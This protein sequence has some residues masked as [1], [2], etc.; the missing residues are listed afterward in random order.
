MFADPQRQKPAPIRRVMALECEDGVNCVVASEPERGI[1]ALAIGEV[2]ERLDLGRDFEHPFMEF[3]LSDNGKR[4]ATIPAND[5]ERFYKRCKSDDCKVIEQQVVLSSGKEAMV[6]RVYSP[7]NI[8]GE[9]YFEPE[10]IFGVLAS[11]AEAKLLSRSDLTEAKEVFERYTVRHAA[12]QIV[13]RFATQSRDILRM[14]DDDLRIYIDGGE[15][16]GEATSNEL[17]KYRKYLAHQPFAHFRGRDNTDLRA[18]DLHD[19]F[20]LLAHTGEFSTLEPVHHRALLALVAPYSFGIPTVTP[21]QSIMSR[22]AQFS[23]QFKHAIE[24]LKPAEEDSEL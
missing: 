10:S 7:R 1:L 14:S 5:R 8:Y 17:E 15:E 11:L 20:R 4:F 24:T 6:L 12:D 21:H 13:T 2:E 16:T 23:R 3:H 18:E 19:A 9:H 22:C